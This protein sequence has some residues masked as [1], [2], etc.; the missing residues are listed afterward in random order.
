[1][2]EFAT[3]VEHELRA[4]GS[5]APARRGRSA[6]RRR[7]RSPPRAAGGSA[8]RS[9]GVVGAVG[10][11]D[12][13]GVALEALEP[14]AD[15][16]AE[17]ARVGA[18]AMQRT[19]GF[20][21]A[22]CR[23]DGRACRRCSRRRRRGSRSRRPPPRAPRHEAVERV[24]DRAGL[25]VGRD[26]DRELHERTRPA[27]DVLL[28]DLAQDRLDVVLERPVRVVAPGTRPRSLIHQRWS[29]M[30][31]SSPSVQSSSRPAISLAERDRLEHRAVASRA[32]RRCCRRPPR[33]ARAWNAAKARTRSALWMLSRTCLPP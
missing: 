5:R 30:R 26:D 13:H 8:T 21:R 29:P 32:R 17:P 33:A 10:H 19:R 18:S 25:V 6:S 14:G 24:A 23:D 12:R 7:S 9:R 22:I 20:A 4:A 15:R 2:T 11:H 1:M 31:A 16:E 28:V 27:L 3:P